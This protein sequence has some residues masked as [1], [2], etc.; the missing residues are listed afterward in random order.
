MLKT[1][2]LKILVYVKMLLLCIAQERSRAEY[3]SISDSGQV[4]FVF[5]KRTTLLDVR[6]II[7]QT[8]ESLRGGHSDTD[9]ALGVLDE[10]CELNGGNMAEVVAGNE[11][12]EVHVVT[13]QTA[14]QKRLFT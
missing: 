3:S 13:L 11:T 10:F 5:G 1:E 12:N 2:G 4:W 9:R 14:R 6:N 8:K 7:Q